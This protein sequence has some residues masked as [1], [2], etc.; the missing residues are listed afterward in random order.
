MRTPLPRK[1]RFTTD[2]AL[3]EFTRE[4]FGEIV[5]SSPLSN[6]P[7]CSGGLIPT[8]DSINESADLAHEIYNRVS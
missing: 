2:E 3:I 1:G 5:M 4:T 8:S 7:D 6:I